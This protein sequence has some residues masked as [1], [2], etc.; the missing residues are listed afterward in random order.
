MGLVRITAKKIGAQVADN[1]VPKIFNCQDTDI[2]KIFAKDGGSVVKL[3]KSALNSN[4]V[5]EVFENVE[6]IGVAIDSSSARSVDKDMSVSAAGSAQGAGFAITRYL[7]VVDSATDTSAEALDLPAAT[8]DDVI[9][10]VNS[11]AVALEVFPASTETI[12]GAA[13]DAVY[14]QPAFSTRHYACRV[15]GAWLISQD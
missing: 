3:K 11:T 2:E 12:N 5:I 6:Q 14:D 1:R 13:A 4:K 7:N 8:V 15:A 9:V 10:V